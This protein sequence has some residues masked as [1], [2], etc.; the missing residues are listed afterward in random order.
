MA[1]IEGFYCTSL[2]LFNDSFTLIRCWLMGAFKCQLTSS[3]EGVRKVLL[4]GILT[5]NK[6]RHD[7]ER[8]FEA[9]APK[10]RQLIFE[11]SLVCRS[12][13]SHVRT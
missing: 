2:S 8:G 7:D 12:N 11:R 9:P 10:K 3:G 4:C 6:K 1:L 5:T 13:I